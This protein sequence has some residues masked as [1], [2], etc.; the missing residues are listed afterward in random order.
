[1]KI[2]FQFFAEQRNAKENG[3]KGLGQGLKSCNVN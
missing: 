2:S 3:K 1:M